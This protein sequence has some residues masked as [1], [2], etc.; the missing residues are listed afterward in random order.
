VLLDAPTRYVV[1]SA[2]T[3]KDT[4]ISLKIERELKSKLLAL[5][6]Q[7]NRTLSNFIDKVLKAE[8]AKNEAKRGRMRTKSRRR[9]VRGD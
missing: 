3:M 4:T 5:A 6:K 8:V 2:R 7:E 9:V 1:L